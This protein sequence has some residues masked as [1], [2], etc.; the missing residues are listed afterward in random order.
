LQQRTEPQRGTQPGNNKFNRDRVV[1]DL[2]NEGNRHGKLQSKQAVEQSSNNS[3]TNNSLPPL[4][5]GRNDI[6][7]QKNE[8]GAHQGPVG[9]RQNG[10]VTAHDTENARLSQN[11]HAKLFEDISRTSSHD[12]VPLTENTFNKRN[13]IGELENTVSDAQDHEQEKK[14]KKKKKKKRKKKNT[15]EALLEEENTSYA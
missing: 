9:V 3:I 15:I 12:T 2:P 11:L 14:K 13:N 5:M 10:K 7:S 6:I 1:K 4:P 8:F